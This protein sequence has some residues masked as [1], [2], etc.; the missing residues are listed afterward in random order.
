MK[1]I[2]FRE[3]NIEIAKN[4]EEY[5]TLPAHKSNDESGTMITCWYLSFWQRVKLLFTGRIWMSEMTFNKPI[6]PRYFSIEKWDVL[7]KEY[8]INQSRK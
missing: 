1:A 3:Q 7:N 6:T 4:Q 2:A 8:F 5:L